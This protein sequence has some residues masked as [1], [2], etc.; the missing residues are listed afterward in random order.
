M[1]INDAGAGITLSTKALKGPT[2]CLSSSTRTFKSS[3]KPS[4]SGDW[5][6]TWINFQ[7]M[8]RVDERKE[9]ADRERNEGTGRSCRN[10][11]WNS[12]AVN[13]LRHVSLL[14]SYKVNHSE[15]MEDISDE[16]KCTPQVNWTIF[17]SF[18]QI[19]RKRQIKINTLTL[20]NNSLAQIRCMCEF[21]SGTLTVYKAP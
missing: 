3:I 2:L 16:H 12:S 18:L 17:S 1:V 21:L 10:L 13:L 20:Y 14:K 4:S 11:K 19:Q 6:F 7:V 5:T 8:Q 15:D 9:M